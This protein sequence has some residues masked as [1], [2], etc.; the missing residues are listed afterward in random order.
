MR[1]VWHL[2]GRFYEARSIRAFTNHLHFKHK[3]GKYF[4]MID[5]PNDVRDEDTPEF[6]RVLQSGWWIVP[7]SLLGLGMWVALGVALWGLLS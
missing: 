2:A 6:D 3:A 1:L 7:A 5:T 4:S